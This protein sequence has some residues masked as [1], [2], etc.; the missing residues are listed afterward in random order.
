[1]AKRKRSN[2]PGRAARRP[3]R[4]AAG[5]AGRFILLYGVHAS[6]AALSNRNRHCR[7]L[8]VT[9]EAE[10]RLGDQLAVL[11]DHRRV[12]VDLEVVERAELDRRLPPGA[13]H[14]GI[15]V[16]AEPLP[17][18][19]LD[20]LVRLLAGRESVILVALDH[21]TDPQNVGAVLRSA[22]AFGA[23]GVIVTDR[24]A[25]AATGA[26]AKAAAGALELMPLLAV[27]NLAR[28]LRELKDEGYWCVGLD[29]AAERILNG[30]GL[31]KRIVLVLGAEGAGLRRLTRECCDLLVRIPVMPAIESLNVST[32]AAVALYELHRRHHPAPQ[33]QGQPRA[34]AR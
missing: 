2:P 34:E 19:A 32:A 22:A 29:N 6:L 3:A 7:R 16:E 14:Q 21:A 8:L 25:P 10:R 11:L 23:A 5:R 18:M 1:M 12:P 28:A 9:E 13:V 27:V 26:M 24:H 4:P 31:P 30:G 17:E 33:P 20:A 15:A